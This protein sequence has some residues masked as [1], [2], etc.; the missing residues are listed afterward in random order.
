MIATMN[1]PVA[2]N[3]WNLRLTP[4]KTTNGPSSVKSLNSGCGVVLSM[5]AFNPCN[6][7]GKIPRSERRQ[8]VDALADADEMHRQSMFLGERHQDAAARGPV[9]FCHDQAGDARRTTKR[10][11]LRQRILSHC[12]VEHQQHRMRRRGVDL[13]DDPNDLFE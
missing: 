10:L 12:G 4:K 3:R 2:T 13:P 8:I 1:A 11:D 6:G 7:V 9:E 5:L